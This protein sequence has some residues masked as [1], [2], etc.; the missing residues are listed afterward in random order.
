MSFAIKELL[1]SALEPMP[2]T[3]PE[4][5]TAVSIQELLSKVEANIAVVPNVP[6]KVSNSL[7]E[8]A[9]ILFC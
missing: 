4:A 5:T 8:A 2:P 6:R 1:T 9:G 7:T 3:V